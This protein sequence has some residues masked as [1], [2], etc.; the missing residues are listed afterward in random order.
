MRIARRARTHLKSAAVAVPDRGGGKL[1]TVLTFYLFG[2]ELQG[3]CVLP[4]RRQTACGSQSRR[5]HF[6]DRRNATT[7]IC[8]R[9]R[10]GP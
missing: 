3:L 5:D 7:L 1:T 9:I 6:N 2:R 8:L 4:Q 10:H